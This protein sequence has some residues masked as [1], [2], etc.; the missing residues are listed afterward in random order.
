MGTPTPRARSASQ[1]RCLHPA[2]MAGRGKVQGAPAIQMQD[3]PSKGEVGGVERGGEPALGAAVRAKQARRLPPLAPA[4]PAPL[5][6]PFPVTTAD[7]LLLCLC[8]PG[9][10]PPVA[11]QAVPL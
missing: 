10:C 1:C 8:E 7:S 9:Q 2:T 3:T 5:Q 6:V 4:A 11:G